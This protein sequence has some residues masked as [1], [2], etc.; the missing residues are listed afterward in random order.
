MKNLAEAIARFP[1]YSALR[2]RRGPDLPAYIEAKEQTDAF[3]NR[4]DAIVDWLLDDEINRRFDTPKFVLVR[5]RD[6]E[7]LAGFDLSSGGTIITLFSGLYRAVDFFRSRWD[8]LRTDAILPVPNSV[9]DLMVIIENARADGTTLFVLDP[10]PNCDRWDLLKEE[11]MRSP[12]ALVAGWA[13][14]KALQFARLELF[15]VEAIARI[16]EGALDAAR[17]ALLAAVAHA[18]PDDPRP[19]FLLGQ[20]ASAT[21]DL[22]LL[23]EVWEFIHWFGG[24]KWEARLKDTMRAGEYDF[25]FED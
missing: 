19:H 23:E 5:S 16:R 6:T 24:E 11:A 25:D 14:A 22:S 13:S 1:E 9:H 2:G 21:Q 8:E 15:M 10:C 4:F 7:S 3:R 17:T 20:V 12:T 18:A